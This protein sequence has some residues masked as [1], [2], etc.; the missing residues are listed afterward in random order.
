MTP[1][2]ALIGWPKSGTD[3]LYAWL[4]AH[5]GIQ[6]STPKEPFFF[7]DPENPLCGRYGASFAH[8]GPEAYARFFDGPAEGRLRFEATTH[9]Y[10]QRTARECF[11]ASGGPL[12]VAALRRPEDRLRSAFHFWRDTRANVD[13]GLGFAEYAQALLDCRVESL[14]S[15]FKLETTFWIAARQSRRW[16]RA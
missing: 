3:S 7:M 2:V 11:A 14:R 5:P 9:S 4:G 6:P 1:D 13:R 10:Y 16:S 12:V 8:D 15:R